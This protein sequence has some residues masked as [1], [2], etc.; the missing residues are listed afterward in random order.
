LALIFHEIGTR[1]AETR[2]ADRIIGDLLPEN[3]TAI[4]AKMF[5]DMKI[6]VAHTG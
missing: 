6:N 1:L 3:C 4:A 5:N 2:S